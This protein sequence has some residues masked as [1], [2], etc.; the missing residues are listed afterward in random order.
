MPL[1]H[2]DDLLCT[3][4]LCRRA[5]PQD[6]DSAHYERLNELETLVCQTD[7]G[8]LKLPERP[9]ASMLDV[10]LAATLDM[11]DEVLRQFVLQLLQA[12]EQLA[13]EMRRRQTHRG[14]QGD[15]DAAV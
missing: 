6:V 13:S 8:L 3:L 4:D 1:S 2:A 7:L 14:V 10:V 9:S 11:E 5:L 12:H 15:S